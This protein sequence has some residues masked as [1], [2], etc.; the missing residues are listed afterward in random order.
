MNLVS[1][2][3]VP[4]MLEQCAEECTELAHACL[5]L[6]RKIR[7]ENPTPVSKKELFD[8][9]NEET[10]DTKVAVDALIK[11]GVI[12]RNEMQKYESLKTLRWEKR[13]KEFKEKGE[14]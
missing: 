9:I 5:K 13:I 8:N 3:G 12:S 7:N 14:E 2:I 11:A 1:D 4:A 10:A 6:A